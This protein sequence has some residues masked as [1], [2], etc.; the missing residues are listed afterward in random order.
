MSEKPP[1]YNPNVG[2]HATAPPPTY[3]AATATAYQPPGSS[4]TFVTQT[5]SYG[6]IPIV[7][8]PV[9]VPDFVC[10]NGCPA[11]RIGVLNE[12][13]TLGGLCCAF[14]FF[15]IGILCCLAMKERRCAN[16]GA[17]FS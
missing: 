12:E 13:F 8:Q 2:P 7:V 9:P 15:P 16:C 3:A 5:P 10:I 1:P 4:T 17:I 14:W 6:T 11:C